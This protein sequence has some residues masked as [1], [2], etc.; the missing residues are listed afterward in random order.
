METVSQNV[1]TEYTKMG[2]GVNNCTIPEGSKPMTAAW[3][4]YTEVTAD[5]SVETLFRSAALCFFLCRNILWIVYILHSNNTSLCLWNCRGGNLE[6]EQKI[7]KISS[8]QCDE[9]ER[10]HFFPNA[11][12]L[13]MTKPF[14][15]NPANVS[16]QPVIQLLY[17][18]VV[19]MFLKDE[20]IK[21]L[22]KY[23]KN[24]SWIS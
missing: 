3:L 24:S 22:F 13:V 18:A 15:T 5:T 10:G 20:L 2:R 6:A 1:I 16:F 19:W 12:F 23:N 4:F 21:V 8:I 11:K 17:P 9:S 7:Q 14:H